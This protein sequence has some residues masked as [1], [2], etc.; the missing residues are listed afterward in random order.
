MDEV[1]DRLLLRERIIAQLVSFF[2][3]F[4]LLLACLGLYGT[5]SFRVAQRTREIGVRMALGAPRARV[6]IMILRDGLTL[7]LAGVAIGLPAAFAFARVLGHLLFA[8]SPYDPLTFGTVVIILAII[9]IV[10]CLLPARRAAN[11]NPMEALRAE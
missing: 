4:A 7:M 9:A 2:S 6:V 11:V 1:I 10:A 3:G 5:L 8:I